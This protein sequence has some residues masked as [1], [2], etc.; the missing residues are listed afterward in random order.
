MDIKKMNTVEIPVQ[1][2]KAMIVMVNRIIKDTESYQDSKVLLQNA[3]T[4]LYS[5]FFSAKHLK[6]C[7]EKELEHGVRDAN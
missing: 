4:K 2:I 7:M 5:I 1:V 6:D 3:D